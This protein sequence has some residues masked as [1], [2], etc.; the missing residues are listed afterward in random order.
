MSC[1]ITEA[2]GTME[3]LKCKLRTLEKFQEKNDSLSGG[4][5]DFGRCS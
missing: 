3:R 1:T 4:F 2:E 5:K